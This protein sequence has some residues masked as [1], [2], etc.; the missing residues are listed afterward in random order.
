[1]I[2][3]AGKPLAGRFVIERE[4]GRGGVGIVYR[5]RDDQS[6]DAVALKVIALPGLDAREDARFRREGRVLAGLNH[7]G[8]VRVVAFGQLEEGQSYV[9]MEWLEGEDIAQRQRRAPLSLAACVLVAAD[10]A[11]ALEAAHAA[12][13]V[14]R[15][16]KPSN[17]ILAGS[18]PDR[19]GAFQV[20]LVDF[21]V[22]AAEDAKLTRT[23]AIVGTP[24][25]MA[26]EQAR[27]DSEVDGRADLYALGATLFEMITVV[28]RT[29]GRRPSRSSR[30]S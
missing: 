22:A 2:A 25:Y 5:A 9:A 21:G 11:D 1:M 30:A 14:H 15:D 3:I 26:P 17:V 6:G 20:K 24:A 12:G 18:G 7:P 16:V 19:G 27:G 10:V 13:I 8:I 28:L 23:G 4:V 29:S